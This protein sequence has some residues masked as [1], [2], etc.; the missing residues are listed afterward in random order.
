MQTL[1][2]LKLEIPIKIIRTDT[3]HFLITTKKVELISDECLE[4][5]TK[6]ILI[7]FLSVK[8]ANF[9]GQF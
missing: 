1:Q 9:D 4:T 2:S 8:G 5:K 3:M 7:M 6:M